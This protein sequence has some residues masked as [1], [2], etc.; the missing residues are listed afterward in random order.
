MPAFMLAHLLGNERAQYQ[1]RINS[2]KF[3]VA[4]IVIGGFKYATANFV[5]RLLIMYSAGQS[6]ANILGFDYEQY[7]RDNFE[8]GEIFANALKAFDIAL[9]TRSGMRGISQLGTRD[10]EIIET[11]F[12]QWTKI[13]PYLETSQ[14]TRSRRIV[15]LMNNLKSELDDEVIF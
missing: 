13:S 5:G 2:I 4:T 6:F 7:L 3:S 12:E 11:L 9:L 14:D 8:H 15:E 1:A 10:I